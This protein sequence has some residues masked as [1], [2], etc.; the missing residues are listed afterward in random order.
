MTTPEPKNHVFL[1][2]ELRALLSAIGLTAAGCQPS[3]EYAAGFS[4]ALTAM[5]V[6]LGLEDLPAQRMQT[7]TVEQPQWVRLGGR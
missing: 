6:G 3:E 7:I 1:R 2:S 4:A 5:S